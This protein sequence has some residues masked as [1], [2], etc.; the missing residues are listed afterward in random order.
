MTGTAANPTE[1]NVTRLNFTVEITDPDGVNDINDTSIRANF[2]RVG[3]S[4]RTN[5]SCVLLGDL[6]GTNANYSC[7]IEMQYFDFNGVWS[8]TV[9]GTDLGNL[10]FVFNDTSNFTYN[11]L[12]AILISN[13]T[14]FPSIS[15]GDINITANGSWTEIN[16][17]GNYNSTNIS[18]SAVN[19]LGETDA[20]AFFEVA[21]FSVNNNTG[22][23]IECAIDND[24]IALVNGT[25][26]W[27]VN[28]TLIRGNH[29]VADNSTGQVNLYYCIRLA[30]QSLSSQ[31][32]STSS[33]GWT[34]KMI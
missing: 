15:S 34:I 13:S 31:V 17:S 11:Q 26:N 19:L 10:S 2:S 1:D 8:I 18:V 21:N 9:G 4:V 14:E 6:N 23:N 3:E 5:N 29:S 32:Y 12:Q 22:A 25:D 24:A 28:A 27:V 33:D 16:N 30:P 20:S 7:E